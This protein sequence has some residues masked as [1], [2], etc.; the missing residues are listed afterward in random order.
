MIDWEEGECNECGE[1]MKI[2]NV[3]HNRSSFDG[4]LTGECKQCQLLVKFERIAYALEMQ[5]GIE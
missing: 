5:V 4:K 1:T 3:P 2:L